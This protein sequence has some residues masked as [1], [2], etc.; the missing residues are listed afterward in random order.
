MRDRLHLLCIGTMVMFVACPTPTIA[1]SDTCEPQVAKIVSVQGRVEA[2]RAGEVQWQ[3]ARLNDILCSGDT[4][5]VQDRSRAAL[6]LINETILRLDQ[7]TTVTFPEPEERG[8]SLLDLLT[9]AIHFFS[10][11]PRTLKVRT[12]FVNAAVEGTEFLITV[13]KDRATVIV[14]E[15]EVA[16]GNE[17]GR[18][19]LQSGKSGVTLAGQA[20]T[21]RVVARPRDAIRWALHYPAIVDYRPADFTNTGWQRMVRRSIEF[22]RAG[23]LVNAF[24]A[25]AE[26]PGE[27]R[28]PRFFTYRAALLLTVGHVHEA[29]DDIAQALALVPNNSHAVALQAIIAVVQN[30]KANALELAMEAVAFDAESA[31]AKVALSY[32]QQANFDLPGALASLQQAVNRD[33]EN[34]LAWARLSELWL[35]VGDLDEALAAASE[36]V[37]RNSDLARTQTVL[38]FAYLTQIKIEDATEAFEKAIELD[39]A[40][41]LPRLGLGLAKIRKSDLEAGRREIEIAASLDP[42]SSLIRS[43]LGKAFF[44]EKRNLLAKNQFDLAKKLDQ[45]DPTPWFYDAIRK[46]TINRPVEA[47]HDIQR[48]IDLNDNRAVFRSRLLLD[49]DLAARS[50]AQA[51]IYR[52]LGFEQLALVEGWKSVNTAPNDYSGHRFL[53]DTYSTLPR[54]DIARV[55]E[56][57]QS[58]LLQPLNITPL[59]PQLAETN[60]FI[61]SGAGP[62]DPAFN[63]FNPLFERDRYAF[64]TNGI[65]GNGSD[66]DGYDAVFSGVQG[67]TS[68]SVGGFHFQAD[69]FRENNDQ[70]Q[71][72]ASAFVQA[73]LS[74]KTSIQA[75]LRST[76]TEKGDLEL[77]FDPNNFSAALRQTRDT[78]SARVGFFHALTPQS[79]ILASV[80]RQDVDRS[81]QDMPFPTVAVDFEGE[82]ESQSTEIQH[83]LRSQ[84]YNI[85]SGIGHV[86]ADVKD[87]NDQTVQVPFPPFVLMSSETVER[88]VDHT[89]LDVYSQISNPD[90]VTVTLGAS[91]DSFEGIVDED[92]FNPKLGVIWKPVPATTVRAAA[93]RVLK[94]TLASDQTLE[95]TQVAGFNQFFDDG[96]GTDAKRYGVAVDQKF[97]SQLYGGIEL[98]KRDLEVPFNVIPPPPPA[99]Q[100]SEVREVDWKEYLNRAYLYWALRPWLAASVELQYEKFERDPEFVGTEEITK[101]TTHRIP[102]GVN[103]YYPSGF[104][105]RIQATYVDQEGDFGDPASG[106]V[107]VLGSRCCLWLPAAQTTWSHFGRGEKPV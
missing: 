61:L 90:H 81:L 94:R 2:Q 55:S 64:Q 25:I 89:N 38:G 98:S 71:D 48:S 11:V 37:S 53:A 103:L 52:D 75:E 59:Q 28:D 46:Q 41:P 57:L 67:K 44:E 10:R 8:V 80:I 35:S 66:L 106:T 7:N 5:R 70:E 39:Q 31:V 104:I 96:E 34:A 95:P 68:F 69:G 73:S 107:P 77:R 105:V 62:S 14:F 29:S 3:P 26:A 65:S 12:P 74:H 92:Q 45:A 18:L 88:D 24:A 99:P 60:L 58:Q 85:V 32:A 21:L 33:P 49:E 15:G 84:R 83:L 19:I 82:D 51:R 79:Q 22:Y 87:V 20:P 102:F 6:A 36:A 97:S 23:D 9:G 30:E 63:E 91:G 78:D 101:L 54:H 50:A 100:V 72:I 13:R 43:Y 86:S 76:E 16:A 17:H 47:L 93:F 40:A 27:I 56:L 4:I 42:N 1:A